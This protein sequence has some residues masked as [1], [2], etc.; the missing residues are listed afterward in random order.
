MIVNSTFET[1]GFMAY[2]KER[3]LDLLEKRPGR[4]VN[5]KIWN[6]HHVMAMVWPEV[7]TSSPD[8]GRPG[9]V[10]RGPACAEHHECSD[11]SSRTGDDTAGNA[12]A[13]PLSSVPV[14]AS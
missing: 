6:H 4:P 9:G 2:L 13:A 8:R 12:P 5:M 7:S 1:A 14:A 10:A 11:C 3:R